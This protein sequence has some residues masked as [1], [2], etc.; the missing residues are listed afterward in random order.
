M[1][2]RDRDV[3]FVGRPEVNSELAEWSGRLGLDYREDV[4]Q[5]DGA[6][7]ASERD[8]LLFA[9]TNPLDQSHMVLV[10]AGNDALRTVKLAASVRD[11]KSGQYEL[12]EDGKASVGF[13]GK[14]E[15]H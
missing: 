14:S 10:V 2:I 7:H 3:I 8:A 11:W 4:I 13:I 9:A 15:K 12:V 1:C 6:A 5:L